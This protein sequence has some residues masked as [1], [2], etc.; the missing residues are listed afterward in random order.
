MLSVNF[1]DIEKA[2]PLVRQIL[3]QTPLYEWPGLSKLAGCQV[4]LK[5]ENHQPVG[6]FKVRGGVNYVGSL[7]PE[8]RVR[9][10][11]GCSTGNHGQSLA[12]ACRQFDVPC[13][14]VVPEGNNPDKNEAIRHLGANLIEQGADFDEAKKYLETELLSH[15]GIYV[16]SANEPKLIAGVGSMGLEIFDELPDPDAIIVPVGLGSG[17]CATGIVAKHLRPETEIIG[18]QA[19]GADAV[20]RSWKKGAPQTTKAANTWAEGIATRS[21][22]RLT[23]Q[24]MQ[25]VMDEAVLVSDQELRSACYHILKQTHNLVEGAGGASVAALLQH[26]EKFADK[27]VVCV[28]SGGN[29]DLNELPA[30]LSVGDNGRES[31]S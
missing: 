8:D 29:L 4:F 26:P 16:H 28:L 3:R 15:G 30:I 25:E 21:S 31:P 17:V 1:E 23:L 11:I 18:V 7:S 6:A 14:I 10:I 19:S 12:Y 27:K 22:A 2:L 5:H 20:F 24:I 13:T 9:G